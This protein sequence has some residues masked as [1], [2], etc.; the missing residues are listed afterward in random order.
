MQSPT[1][2]NKI[3]AELFSSN[4]SEPRQVTRNCM[5]TRKLGHS[6]GVCVILLLWTIRMI[7]TSRNR[8]KHPERRPAVIAGRSRRA[9]SGR[10]NKHFR[11]LAASFDCAAN[12]GPL[13]SGCSRDVL[14]INY[15]DG[16]YTRT[17]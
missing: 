11:D 17:S 1:T 7:R 5:D 3:K 13:R 8:D 2:Y 16:L 6:A 9:R 15:I 14:T 10:G 12:N 4:N